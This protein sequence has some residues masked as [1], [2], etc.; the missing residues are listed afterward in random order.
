MEFKEISGIVLNH[1]I[2]EVLKFSYIKFLTNTT[3]ESIKLP[4]QSGGSKHYHLLNPSYLLHIEIVKTR[5]NWILRNITQYSKISNPHEYADFI[6]QAEIVKITL[7]HILVDQEVSVLEFF[8]KAMENI[9]NTELKSYENTL[10]TE[11]GF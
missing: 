5:K 10:L 3:L 11:L 1:Y 7:S 2:D 4:L 8:T 6:K 9:K